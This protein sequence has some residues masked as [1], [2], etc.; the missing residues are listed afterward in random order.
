MGIGYIISSKLNVVKVIMNI[1]IDY[2]LNGVMK[3]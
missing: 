1:V 3:C 2:C